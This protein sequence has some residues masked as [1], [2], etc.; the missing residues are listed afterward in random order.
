M[1]EQQSAINKCQDV[2]TCRLVL[3]LSEEG[4]GSGGLSTVQVNSE[5]V[6]LESP[7]EAGEGLGRP[8]MSRELIP[9]LRSQNREELGLGRAMFGYF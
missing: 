6:G 9:P 3:G 4:G 5:Q 1:H 8:D 7:A 2:Q